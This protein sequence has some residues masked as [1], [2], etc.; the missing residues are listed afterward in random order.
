MKHETQFVSDRL[1]E[2][3]DLSAI[4]ASIEQRWPGSHV[5]ATRKGESVP[6]AIERKKLNLRELGD[7]LSY[8]VTR[9]TGVDR[10][11][12]E[13]VVTLQPEDAENL[14]QA[15]AAIERMA[16]YANAIRRVIAKGE[17]DDQ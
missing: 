13:T 9:C 11:F 12:S 7:F 6:Q 5:V 1:P 17:K 10:G 15:A 3:A 14:K 4:L 2:R 16:P 8:L